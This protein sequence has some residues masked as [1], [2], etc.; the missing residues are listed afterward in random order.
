MNI[1]AVEYQQIMADFINPG[2]VNPDE[3]TLISSD[4][5]PSQLRHI[6]MAFARMVG[7]IAPFLVQETVEN[8]NAT[9]DAFPED[10]LDD[11]VSRLSEEISNLSL[12]EQFLR[13]ALPVVQ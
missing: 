4:D 2:A 11:L 10:Q 6:S 5:F 3:I 12:K 7:P 1:E 13:K 8:M 9:T